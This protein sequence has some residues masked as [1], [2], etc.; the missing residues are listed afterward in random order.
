MWRTVLLL[1]IG[2]AGCTSYAERVAGTCQRLGAPRGTPQY[3]DCV[4]QQ[5]EIDQRDRAMWSGTTAVGA[6]LIQGPPSVYV[7]GR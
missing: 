7:Y 3:W 6:S 2:L 1:A 5:V 4:H